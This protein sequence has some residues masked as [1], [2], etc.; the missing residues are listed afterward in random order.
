MIVAALAGPRA[1]TVEERQPLEQFVAFEQRLPQR[2]KIA[3]AGQ[4]D[5]KLLAHRA[6]AAVAADEI[7][8][9]DFLAC[10]RPSASRAR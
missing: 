9:A 4:F 6:R 5:I 7:F 3:L 1:V 2:E 8:G 10:R